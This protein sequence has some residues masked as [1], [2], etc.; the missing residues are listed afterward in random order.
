MLANNETGALQPVK[1]VSQYCRQKGILIATD[2]AQAVGKIS[3]KLIDIGDPDM[4]VIVGHKIGA[5]KGIACLYVRPGCFGDHGHKMHGLLT[6]GG[7]EHGWRG[8]TPNV[9]YIVGLGV[10]AEHCANNLRQ[11]QVHLENMRCRLLGRLREL[12]GEQNI[13]VNGPTDARF[14][15]PNTLSIA[16]GG[17]IHSGKLLDDVRNKVAASGGA[18]CH[19]ANGPVSAILQAMNVPN[20]WARGTVRLSLGPHTSPDEVD[21]AAGYLAQA[22][23][24]QWL[25]ATK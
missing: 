25:C 22:L 4:V 17:G 9:P 19:S 6:G 13:L 8:G 18:T 2:A 14:R 21:R 24:L 20:I 7:Q 1:E 3:V 12:V 11:N 23:Q 15:L 16:F 5:P 10:A